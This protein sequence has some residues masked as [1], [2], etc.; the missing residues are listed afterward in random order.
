MYVVVLGLG[1]TFIVRD[2]LLTDYGPFTTAAKLLYFIG[3]YYFLSYDW[4][5]YALLIESYPYSLTETTDLVAQGRF[6][7]DLTHL[8]LK[9]G[10]IFLALQTLDAVTLAVAALLFAG[11]HLAIVFWHMLA[12]VEYDT[13]PVSWLSH[14]VMIIFYLVF[15]VLMVAFDDFVISAF[16]RLLSVLV[17]IGFAV[18]YAT[19]RKRELLSQLE[20]EPVQR[21][22]M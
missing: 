2:F 21:T 12:R 1:F 16:D 13:Y 11:W 4:I 20:S 19:Y 22:A 3:L 6:Y 9:A 18:G 5:A 7:A 10:L 14:G 17:L 8:L 15:A